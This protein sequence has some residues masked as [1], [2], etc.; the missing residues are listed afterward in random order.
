MAQDNTLDYYLKITW[1]SLANRYNQLA[2]KQGITQAT[3]YLLINIRK[4]GT[5]VTQLANLLG[6]KSTS[7]SRILSG[8]EKQGLIYRQADSRDKRSVR[9][10]LT[11]EGQRKRELAKDIVR[12]FNKYCE[13]HMKETDRI[14]LIELLKRLN[15]LTIKYNPD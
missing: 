9:I 3:G 8:M 12:N 6:V 4:E 7:L 14:K 10:F 15:E 5:A 11:E 1:Q 13:S 2:V